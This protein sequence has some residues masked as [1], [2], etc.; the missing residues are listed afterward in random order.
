MPPTSCIR[1]SKQTPHSS[2]ARRA[3]LHLISRFLRQCYSGPNSDPP[4]LPPA[5]GADCMESAPDK[6]HPRLNP[7]SWPAWRRGIKRHSASFT[8]N[9]HPALPWRTGS[10]TIA[11]RRRNCSRMCT[12]KSGENR[13]IRCRSRKPH[14]LAGDLTRSRAIDRLRSRAS[15][16]QHV[17]ADSF[18]APAGLRHAGRQP[19]SI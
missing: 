9:L 5:L 13:Q 1:I 6:P 8:I 18:E 14:R 17:V 7:N 11:M 15:R 3:N 19:Q 4:G 16:G 2:R 12:W 10:S